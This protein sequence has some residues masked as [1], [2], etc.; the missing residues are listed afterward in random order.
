MSERGVGDEGGNIGDEGATL[1]S[2]RAGNIG[3]ELGGH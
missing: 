2:G 1:M 3:D